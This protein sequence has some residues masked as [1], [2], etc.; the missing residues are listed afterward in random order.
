MGSITD[1]PGIKVGH[2]THKKALTGCTVILFES[3]A[4]AAFD[5]RGM[6]SG[7]RQID[8]LTPLHVVNEIHAILL[9][10]G[11]SFGLDAAGGVMRY[12]EEKGIGFDTGVAR[13]PIV[14]SAVL[15][16]LGL[17]DPKIRPDAQMGYKA[18]LE[19]SREV[20]EGSVGAGTGATVGKLLGLK[21][22]MK[23]GLGTWSVKGPEKVVVG[24][25]VVLNAFGDVFDPSTGEQIAG[26]LDENG[27]LL[28][29]QQLLKQGVKKEK[30]GF[31]LENTT[32]VVLATNVKLD[33]IELTKLAQMASLTLG[34]VISPCG[35]P[36][37]GDIVFAVSTGEEEL[38][39]ANVAALAEGAIFEAVKRAIFLADGFKII[40]SWRDVFGLD[41]KV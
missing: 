16:D 10:G 7:T 6:A 24:A 25:L 31:P 30:F 4:R 20:Q 5:M 36:F 12:L 38:P 33:K 28:N 11:S 37:D 35:T 8:S 34:K 15:F 29:T 41:P 22:A 3:P 27:K 23:G 1:V 13:I 9:T 21:R 2:F 19:A 17:G 32:L 18:C 39:L 40:P 14:P 26:P